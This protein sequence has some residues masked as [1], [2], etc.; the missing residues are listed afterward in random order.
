MLWKIGMFLILLFSNFT[1]FIG[2]SNKLAYFVGF[3]EGDRQL[4]VIVMVVNDNKI[5]LKTYLIS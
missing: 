5:G 1:W 2:I 4:N 3:W